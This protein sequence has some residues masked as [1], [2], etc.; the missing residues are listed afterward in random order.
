MSRNPSLVRFAV[1]HP[2]T[3]AALTVAVTLALAGIA[4]LPSLAPDALPFLHAVRVDTDPENMLREDEPV[5]VFH[6]R[7]KETFALHDIVV[8]GVVNEAHPQGVWN[9]S[10]LARIHA[11]AR[12]AET[13]RRPDPDAGG[14]W[15][16]VVARD[17]ISPPTVDSI[18]P[19]SPVRFE[20]LMPRPPLDET[21]ALEVRRRA[22][23]I[24]FLN[25]TLV[26]DV[27]LTP[28]G[29]VPDPPPDGRLEDG[30]AVALYL[31]LT[32][33][34][35]SHRV[36]VALERQMPAIWA[37]GPVRVALDRLAAPGANEGVDVL[38]R[39]GQT[40][41]F[42]APDAEVLRRTVT[43]LASRAGAEGPPA[44]FGAVEA[45]LEAWQQAHAESIQALEAAVG[46]GAPSAKAKEEDAGPALP[47]GLG[48]GGPALPEGPGGDGPALPEGLGGP[49]TEKSPPAPAKEEPWPEESLALS[50]DLHASLVAALGEAGGGWPETAA[51]VLAA[52]GK[53]PQ[54]AREMLAAVRD[55]REDAAALAEAPKETA[56]R[57]AAAIED[58]A[59]P[60]QDRAYV[61]GLPVA[62]DTFGVEMFKQMAISA[63]LAMLVVF[64]LMWVFFRKLVIIV[65]PMIVAMVAVITTMGLLI[66]TG[67]TVHIMSSMIPIFI[68]PIA[69]L[70]A[71]HILSEFFD[72]YQE[73][74]DRRRT[75]LAVMRRLFVPMLFTSLTTA[76]GFGSLA[77]TPIPPVQVFGLFIAFGVMVAWAATV[78]FIPAFVMF[79]PARRL[80]TFGLKKDEEAAHARTP[81]A[82]LL[83]ALGRG[84]HRR[85]RVVLAAT[86]VA[87][88][89]AAWGITKIHVNDN[90]IRWFEPDHP[91]RVADRVLN[92]HFG[93]TYMAYLVLEA[94]EPEEGESPEE[95]FKRPDVLDHMSRLQRHLAE[96]TGGR[97]GKSNSLVDIVRTVNRAL[98]AA[99]PDDPNRPR[100]FRVPETPAGVAQT[101]IQYESSH[102]PQDLAH[103]VTRDERQPETHFRTSSLWVQ[104]RSGDNRDMEAVVRSLADWWEAN[105]PPVAM[106]PPRWFGLTYIN[107]V[108]QDKM[109]SGMRDAFLGSFLVVLLMM[110]LLFRSGLWGLLSMVPLTVTVGVIYG[111]VGFV[112]KDYDMPTA[113]LSS[114]TLGLAVDYAIHFLA[115]SRE[116]RRDAGS[117]ADA[118]PYVFGEPARA[119]LRNVIVV[120]VGFLPLLAAPLVPYQTVGVFM[121][122]ILFLAGVATLL[123]LPA[124]IRVLE[125]LLFPKT[126]TCRLTCA[127]GTCTT[128]ILVA[129]ALV[130]VNLNQFLGVGWTTLTFLG[131]PVVATLAGACALLSWRE[132]C[133]RQR[134]AA[135]CDEN[136][137]GVEA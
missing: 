112:G 33:K 50:R 45:A 40:A 53:R 106:K 38:R 19:G 135:A 4:A 68:M 131:V 116:S 137:K 62:E 39:L 55:L 73:T 72:R 83:R 109:V 21:G 110:I 56:G 18:E 104:L 61:T 122:A 67:H 92:R 44:G 30:R 5:R 87:A 70:D 13:L 54:T 130:A 134:E 78:T 11:L 79:I 7:M 48:G 127:A 93:G 84:T 132:K 129:A 133:R 8:V 66:A 126:R 14:R 124:L 119:I 81:M 46:Q 58:T 107:V 27:A 1:D 98:R 120:G 118:V 15:R 51:L 57:V 128:T 60:G 85:A 59:Y 42:E 2:K 3:V 76:A 34:D 28:E 71:I 101:L 12:F 89:L 77:L 69:V 95:T 43:F 41:A 74:R 22:A 49:P 123:I 105:P 102:R 91:I 96:G 64:L 26:S 99:G 23:R 16:G 29:R 63:P 103:F 114:L 6:D 10:S 121:A 31:P 25:G 75:M 47:E 136:E 52:R 65:S 17:L 35:Q 115:R 113:V 125:P 37:W 36:Y 9:P 97:V 86:A 82:R 108:W 24:P 90:P 117:W 80:E 88:A 111:A 94:E 100:Y 32:S 20:W